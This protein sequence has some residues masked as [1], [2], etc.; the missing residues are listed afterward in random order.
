MSRKTCNRIFLVGLVVLLYLDGVPDASGQ[1]D[2]MRFMHYNLLNYGNSAN[3]AFV[4]NPRLQTIFQHVQPDLL[5][6]NEMLSDSTLRDSLLFAL[7]PGWAKTNYSNLGG[8]TQ[9]NHL[10]YKPTQ[11]SFRGQTVISHALRDII[12]YRLQYRDTLTYPHDTVFLTAIVCH[13]KAGNGSSE[14]AERATETATVAAFLNGL[15]CNNVLLAGDMN[16]YASAEAC[17]QNLVAN[18]NLCGKLFDPINRP[19][20]WHDAASFADVHT[21]SPRT[22]NLSDGGATGG[23]DD[24]F[25]QVLVSGQVMNDAAGVKYLPGSYKAIGQD[26]LHFNAG[27]TDAP[28]NT[29]V[30]ANVVQALHL[31][32]DHLPVSADFIFHATPLPA[33][34]QTVEENNINDIHVL[35]PVDDLLVVHFPARMVG[36][37]VTLRL[38]TLMGQAALQR[39]LLVESE[40]MKVELPEQLPPSGQV[41]F[42]TVCDKA[43][44]QRRIKLVKR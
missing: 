4:K 35:N 15:G 27:L 41:F 16:V 26:G 34:I 29:S 36:E 30:P 38:H 32:S 23:L 11:F 6:V 42:L 12:A 8:Q 43:G 13:L 24:R 19:G 1:T 40:A 20:A 28:V 9:T 33:G 10:F 22:A 31:A 25:D 17:Y 37:T 5:S 18:P 39:T 2:T 14:E 44:N 21:Q 7:G 3:R